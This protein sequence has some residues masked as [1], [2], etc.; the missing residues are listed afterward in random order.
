MRSI[1]ISENLKISV[2]SPDNNGN[3][4]W[5]PVFIAKSKFWLY[6]FKIK[7]DILCRSLLWLNFNFLPL[8][9]SMV[10]ILNVE[11]AHVHWITYRTR[12]IIK[13]NYLKCNNIGVTWE[14]LIKNSSVSFFRDINLWKI[15][16]IAIF[17][18]L[19]IFC[20]HL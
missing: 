5:F 15:T 9:F 20:C 3:R 18:F 11:V 14:L 16:I 6:L 12:K 13:V 2:K 7:D 8:I 19:F 4:D 17:D 10:Q 1:F